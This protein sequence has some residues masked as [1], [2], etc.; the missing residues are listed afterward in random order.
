MLRNHLMRMLSKYTTIYT[1]MMAG[2]FDRDKDEEEQ[3]MLEATSTHVEMA[4]KTQ[5]GIGTLGVLLEEYDDFIQMEK[6]REERERQDHREEKE[7]RQKVEDEERHHR[8]QIQE[9]ER[10]HTEVME[11]LRITERNLVPPTRGDEPRRK[12]FAG[13]KIPKIQSQECQ[14]DRE[15]VQVDRK[16]ME[17]GSIGAEYGVQSCHNSQPSEEILRKAREAIAAHFN[18]DWQCSVSPPA[19]ASLA[20]EI[21]SHES[22]QN[23]HEDASTPVNGSENLSFVGWEGPFRKKKKKRKS[24]F[25]TSRRVLS[26]VSWKRRRCKNPSILRKSWTHPPRQQK[27]VKDP[28]IRR[29]SWIRFSRH[30]KSLRNPKIRWKTWS[31]PISSVEPSRSA[32]STMEHPSLDRNVRR[33]S[34]ILR[35]GSRGPKAKMKVGIRFCDLAEWKT[36]GIYHDDLLG[37]IRKKTRI[38]R[39][40]IHGHKGESAKEESAQLQASGRKQAVPVWRE[41]CG[42]QEPQ[43][44]VL[45][46]RKENVK[47]VF[48]RSLAPVFS[49]LLLC[50]LSYGCF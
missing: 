43:C 37:R 46:R 14:M 5:V 6:E 32:L 28:G 30:R 24:S 35:H 12:G 38:S 29:M 20:Q 11:R 33:K 25:K 23:F 45:S 34:N 10:K 1:E 41:C 22:S 39:Y 19:A 18:P 13:R 16:S 3:F 31:Q 9:M 7:R 40:L 17:K 21:L 50:V 26:S 15:K 42:V 4:S 2:I 47:C 36:S 48:V 49:F 8:F 44:L 27:V